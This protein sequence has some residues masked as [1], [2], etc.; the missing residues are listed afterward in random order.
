MAK[1]PRT[2]DGLGAR[3]LAF[4]RRAHRGYNFTASETELLTE[5]CRCLDELEGM[6][7]SGTAAARDLA[8]ARTTLGRLLAQLG[9]QDED[10]RTMPSP[11]TTR[12]RTAAR[13]RWHGAAS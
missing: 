6:A 13:Q 4:W 5:V 7:A 12:A 1:T 8:T 2:P 3:G 10:D 11:G 9:L